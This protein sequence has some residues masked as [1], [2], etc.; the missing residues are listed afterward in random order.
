MRIINGQIMTMAGRNY[1][2]GYLPV[3]EKK[4]MAVGDDC[5][6]G[7]FPITSQLRALDAVNPMD[8]AFYDAVI[9]GITSLMT[10]PGIS[11]VVGGQFVFMK[12]Q[13]HLIAEEIA[14]SGFPVIVGPGLASRS[15]IE[16]RNMSFKTAGV[17]E[18]A[19]IK[20][21]IMTDHPVSLIRYLPI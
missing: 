8:A 19:G 4:I 3:E 20:T 16:V 13:G 12:V 17:L 11:N 10:R 1:E 18:R 21:A 9:A 6:E 14:E 5:N 7:T 2:N 15:K